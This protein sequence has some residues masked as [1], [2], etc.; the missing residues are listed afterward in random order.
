M[1]LSVGP[2]EAVVFDTGDDVEL[3]DGCLERLGI[4]E[5]PLLVLSHDHSDH[6][7]GAPG[8]L[9][10]RR[11]PAALAPAG[12]EDTA[13]GR[14]LA[15]EGVELLAA[16]RGQTFKVGSWTLRVLWPRPGYAGTVNDTSVVI[17]ADGTHLSALFTGDIEVPAQGELLR[18][19]DS[20]LLAVTVLNT[21]HHGSGTQDPDFLAATRARVSVTSVG[22]DNPY[23]HPAP[24]TRNI[25]ERI[26]PVNA[27][28]DTDG[29]VAVLEDPVRVVSR[30]PVPGR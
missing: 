26:A 23:G 7:D 15:E 24:F 4:R 27:R 29:D 22:A 16:E 28:T 20:E 5:V 21:P 6:V 9:R 3:V 17:R 18:G 19:P 8:V 14:L 25:L 10:H 1:A 30:G 2:G 11:V 13:V 12:F